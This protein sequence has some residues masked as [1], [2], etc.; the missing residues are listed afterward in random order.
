MATKTTTKTAWISV[1]D[2][3]PAIGESVIIATK[4]Y[5]GEGSYHGAGNWVYLKLGM[6]LSGGQVTHWQP[7]PAAPKKEG[8]AK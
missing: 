7:L 5:V 4:D 6:L 1:A 8:A 2:Q 3:T